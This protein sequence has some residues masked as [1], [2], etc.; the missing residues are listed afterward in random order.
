MYSLSQIAQISGSTFVGKIN[1]VIQHYLIDSRSIQSREHTLF[2]A[3]VTPRN[4]GHKYID[5]MIN[6]GVKAFMVQEGAIEIKEY[7]GLD[8]SFVVCQNP[9]QAIQKLAEHHRQQFNIPVIGITGSNGKTVVKEWLYQ[10]LKS[11]YSICRSPKSYNS[12]IGVPLS[13]LNLQQHHT[14]AIFEAGISTVNE[15]EKLSAI[16]KPDIGIITSFG[17]AHDEGFPNTAVKL[18]E[19]L[20]LTA[21]A[22]TVITNGLD[23]LPQFTDRHWY[24]I[25]AATDAKC[26]LVPRDFGFQLTYENR[27]H[28][29]SLPF[30]DKA[31]I[32]NAATCVVC[33][34]QLGFSESEIQERLRNLQP[35]ALRL[36]IKTG[37]NHSIV[38]ND[39]YNSDLESIKIALIFMQQQNR[40]LQKVVVVSD[41][42]QS[43]IASGSLY[44]QLADLFQQ[45]QIDRIIGIGEEISKHKFL[46]GQKALFYTS[47]GAFEKAFLLNQYLF[48]NACVLLKGARSFGFETISQLLQL[49]SHD[50]VFEINL[51]RLID[52]V[53]HYK[54]L[55]LP[56]V[57]IMAMVK[58]MGYGSGSVEIARTLQ[59]RGVDYLA[60]AYADE[61]VELRK[62]NVQLPIMVMN[63]EQDAFDDIIQYHLE[64]ELYGF[65][66]VKEFLAHLDKV[67]LSEAYPVH[68]KLDTGMHRLGFEINELPELCAILKK[69]ESVKVQSVF[70]HLVGADNPDL[71]DFTRQQISAFEKAANLLSTSLHSSF[72][73]HLCNSAGISRFKEAHFD[74]VR[75]GIG[76]Y[77]IGANKHEQSQLAN[78]GSLK[79]RISQIKTVEPGESVGYN[80]NGKINSRTVLA[81]IPI[82]YAD[83]FARSLGN[84]NH[85]VFIHGVFCKVIGNV[86]MDM[87][88]VDVTHLACQEGDE[89]V[90]FESHDQI[91]QMA[92]AMNTIPYEVL[93]NVSGRVKRVYIQE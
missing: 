85:G 24:N 93:T 70:S 89:V 61:G 71:D 23:D 35:V 78:V 31:S 11:N 46:F 6:A 50:T 45:N 90:I 88:M 34:F 75:L 63:P 42:E 4:N 69:A 13:V 32:H 17:S 82:G 83:G 38:I 3:L 79:T 28:T 49:K 10:L 29:F 21:E 18:D 30:N 40:G 53:N 19:K 22:K 20:K 39:F 72:L 56:N 74:M 64:P 36:E 2:I 92:S 87:C 58:A 9:L 25:S 16:I 27:D 91:Q 48:N 14:L 86:C 73:K 37:I 60:V 84:G 65:K 59:H 52:N 8:V 67:G 76:M 55:L 80:R 1:H 68:V 12:Q 66:I 47:T 33:M 51:N 15:M 62:A 77:G 43:G 7:A 57:K 5:D 44:H 81:T 54:G 41:I 26:V